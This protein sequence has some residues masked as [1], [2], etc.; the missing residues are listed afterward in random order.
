RTVYTSGD[1]YDG[2][3]TNQFNSINS[4]SYSFSRSLDARLGLSYFK[5]F[6]GTNYI[7][8]INAEQA[9]NYSYY[10]AGGM[11]RKIFEINETFTTI[12][13]YSHYS[14]VAST[15][16]TSKQRVN[17]FLLGTKYYPLRQM[18]IA[19]GA[20]YSF[21]NG[22]ENDAINYYGSISV[23]F[24]LLD[25]SLDYSYGKNKTDNRVEKKFMANVKKRF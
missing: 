5:T 13:E 17:T 3:A 14:D 11:K 22:F 10:Q 21:V 15:V 12:E 24:R 23:N 2:E 1:S 4:V 25:A 7:D 18:M 16:A 8:T 9:V 20:R 19:G 6:G